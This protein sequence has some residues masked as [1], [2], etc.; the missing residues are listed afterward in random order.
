MKPEP[1]D[2]SRHQPI[3]MSSPL[4]RRRFLKQSLAASVALPAI[5]SLEENALL[6]QAHASPAE[7]AP[8]APSPATPKCPLGKIGKVQI[9]RLICGGNLISGYAHSRD[10]IYVSSL[11][12]HYF[13]EEKIMETWA[14]SEQ[15]GINTMVAYGGDPQVAEVYRKYRSRGGQIQYLAQIGPKKD[16]LK[17]AVQQAVDAGAVGAFLVGNSGD[18]WSRDG[19]IGLIGQ[20]LKHIKDA[21]LIAGVAGHELRTVKAIEASGAAPDFYVKTLHNTNYW[22]RRQLAQEQEVID[23]YGI[24]NYWCRQPKETIAFMAELNRPWI[25]YKV[26]AA[27]AILPRSG[28]RYAFENGADF[29]LVGMFDFQVA[30]NVAVT[31]ELLS[32]KLDRDRA[33]MA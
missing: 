19:S 11:L 27:G 5:I 2:S 22:S 28:F 18:E 12:L 1:T 3:T 13:T 25:A 20:L 30:E 4:A 29:A 31:H 21:G 10:L 33:W 15:H 32:G 24:D 23:N 14:L 9:S 16:D 7:A 17:T 26:L 8:A 6:R